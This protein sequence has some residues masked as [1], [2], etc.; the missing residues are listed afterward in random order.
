M[1]S[2]MS[3][4]CGG[5]QPQAKRLSHPVSISQYEAAGSLVTVS[6]CWLMS[7]VAGSWKVQLPSSPEPL[8]RKGAGRHA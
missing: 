4:L 6:A 8:W 5:E 3:Y 1:R 2:R 7:W